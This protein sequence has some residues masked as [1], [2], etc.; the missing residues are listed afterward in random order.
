MLA[1]IAIAGLSPYLMALQAPGQNMEQP[2][3][4]IQDYPMHK[5][6]HGHDMSNGPPDPEKQLKL[7]AD[8][9]ESEFNHHLA[10]F[11]VALGGAF[12]LLQT[13]MGTRWLSARYV[14]PAS[15]LASG[16]FVL[17]WSDTELWPFGGRQW[18]EA[19]QHNRE[20]L[21]HKIFAA[22]LL[23]LGCIEWFRLSGT[24]RRAW[25]GLVFP[26]LA[27]AG[28]VLLLFHQ[29]EGG[30]QGPD[31]MELMAQIQHQHLSYA[32]VGI[33]IGLAKAAVELKMRGHRTF[34]HVWP[35]LMGALGILLMFYRE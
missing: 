18:I 26:V 8:K 1:F 31:H 15:F 17:V 28:S 14:W 35:L 5:G 32:V 23:G 4:I 13:A 7:I 34:A 3:A 20:V 25:S 21:Q 2:A 9:K 33:G 24:L 6:H 12:I 16:I 29:H 22:L 27:I 19:L 30:M 11:F 10:G